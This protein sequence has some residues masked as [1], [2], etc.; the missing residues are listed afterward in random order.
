MTLLP[1]SCMA[2]EHKN[3]GGWGGVLVTL[4]ACSSIARQHVLYIACA[5]C[6]GYGSDMIAQEDVAVVCALVLLLRLGRFPEP[7]GFAELRPLFRVSV[8]TLDAYLFG[9]CVDVRDPLQRFVV[10]N[11]LHVERSWVKA[12]V[13]PL[14]EPLK[15]RVL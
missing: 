12:S 7:D 10:E 2:R 5:P 6:R 8:Y 13:A 14:S 9:L 15:G 1:C 3:P 11:T 4:L